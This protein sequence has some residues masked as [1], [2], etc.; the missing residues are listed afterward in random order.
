MSL[1]TACEILR[2]ES[3]Q[4]HFF[5]VI[6]YPKGHI[7]KE[8][9]VCSVTSNDNDTASMFISVSVPNP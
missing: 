9:N 2:V 4:S 5:V 6:S 3:V 8:T 1:P 7:C